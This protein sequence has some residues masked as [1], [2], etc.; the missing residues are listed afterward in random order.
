MDACRHMTRSFFC[1]RISKVIFGGRAPAPRL[2]VLAAAVIVSAAF[3]FSCASQKS[4]DNRSPLP[5][6]FLNPYMEY[7]RAEYLAAVGFGATQEDSKK[8]AARALLNEAAPSTQESADDAISA[9]ELPGVEYGQTHEESAG[10]YYTVAYIEK[11]SVASGAAARLAAIERSIKDLTAQR[12]KTRGLD[13]FIAA[14]EAEMLAKEAAALRRIFKAIDA[15]LPETKLQ[16]EEYEPAALA[17]A[18]KEAAAGVR[19]YTYAYLDGA[20]SSRDQLRTQINAALKEVV[21]DFG[22]AV[23]S[24]LDGY[25]MEANAVV[26]EVSDAEKPTVSWSLFF[27]LNSQTKTIISKTLK[28]S[29]V[30]EDEARDVR[31]VAVDDMKEAVRAALWDYIRSHGKK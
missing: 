1:T 22:F 27:G 2:L 6:Q 7:P 13:A 4:A 21:A 18:S 17:A 14:H 29:S 30:Q 9:E 5:V 31:L 12:R 10:R 24:K 3:L 19:F 25:V 15:P 11:A 20:G 26:K 28:G 23:S 8:A 16:G